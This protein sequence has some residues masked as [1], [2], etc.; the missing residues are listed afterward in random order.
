[1]MKN[2][3]KY[4]TASFFKPL[5][6]LYLLSLVFFPFF[7][8]AQIEVDEITDRFDTY[9][10]QLVPEKV[11]LHTNRER[12]TLGDTL[13][14]S[15]Y[16]LNGEKHSPSYVSGVLYVELINPV[17][18][19]VES[20]KLKIDSLG[21]TYGTMT[22]SDSLDAGQY[23]LRAYTQYQMN[24]DEDY[25]FDKSIKLL[26]RL[27][28]QD[29][30][31]YSPQK[32]PQV[33]LDFFPE[34]GE[35]VTGAINLIA[36]KAT[37]QY[38][39]PIDV[40]GDVLDDTGTKVAT[41]KCEH[42][43]MG[44]FQLQLEEGKK[45]TCTYRFADRSFSQPL[46]EAL[47]KGY[48]LHARRASG[49]WH[50][51]VNP[52]NTTIEHSFL[53]MQCRGEIL[54]VIGPQPGAASIRFSLN[55]TDLP[56]GIIQLTF[57][58]PQHKAVS[59]RLIYNENPNTR[60]LLEIST[61]K[62]SY[63]RRSNVDV[64]FRLAGKA[65]NT[66]NLATLSTTVI[67]QALRMAPDENISSFLFLTSDLKGYV[68]QPAY[69]VNPGNPDRL[70]HVDLLM[71]TQGW[72]RFEWEK[73]INGEFP[74][75][76]HFFEQGIRVEGTVRNY[77]DRN[78]PM[79]SDLKLQFADNPLFQL[80]TTSLDNGLFW[81]DKLNFTD[82]MTAYVKAVT[83]DTRKSKKAENNTFI[84]IHERV[85]PPIQEHYLLPY[86]V[87]QKD[88]VL[89]ERGQRLLDIYSTDQETIMLQELTVKTEKE[90]VDDPFSGRQGM[91]YSDP[92]HRIML[93]S[94]P[95]Y[96]RDVFQYLYGVPGLVV[97]GFAPNASVKIRGI[98][99]FNSPTEPLYILDGLE[100]DV[101]F[102][103]NLNTM[104]ILFIDVLKGP[105][106]N[107]YGSR[108]ATGAI[109]LYSRQ[110]GDLRAIKEKDLVGQ[111]V[112][113]LAGYTPPRKFYMPD[114]SNSG[115]KENDT[116]DFRS[117]IYWNPLLHVE[118]GQAADQFY[119]SDETGEFFI[120]AEGITVDGVPF[121][122]EA[123]FAV[124]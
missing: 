17:D 78:R 74:E 91:I 62:Q 112:F 57:F 9:Y 111:A 108:G 69:Y 103:N 110:A 115:E 4:R 6:G 95:H 90:A 92:D 23:A 56:N 80:E 61:H 8:M 119:T 34:G 99:S 89:I 41:I 97:T 83:E 63:A 43:G 60:Q 106:A 45:Y 123:V 68:H 32:V 19:I 53:I 121:S 66:P 101:A 122:G 55:E 25:F 86:R 82:T 1:M 79:V 15:A 5:F 54:Y 87:T 7:S 76:N 35:L 58:D 3:S 42:D 52:I 71:M 100:R 38:G 40:T 70:K 39:N 48:L 98:E 105:S 67:P 107:V 11:Y 102:V 64:D 31:E 73:L 88:K 104:N 84:Q 44:I 109:V 29:V 96:Y 22:L 47:T 51:V 75:L 21:R 77:L 114:Y 85:V 33:R 93:D 36:F 59:E 72:R 113:R 24:F 37:D 50:T 14:L 120:Y 81:F 2:F 26:P 46:P 117:T 27:K 118:D 49:R 30:I 20:L 94:F 28:T 10:D 124:E 65:G 116:P 13:Y 18:S 12:F 16:V